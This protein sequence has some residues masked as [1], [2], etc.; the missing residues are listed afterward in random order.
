MQASFFQKILKKE[1]ILSKRF[2]IVR[3]EN[4][5]QVDAGASL[6]TNRRKLNRTVVVFNL[7][8]TVT[9][10]SP[11]SEHRKMKS[12]GHDPFRVAASFQLAEYGT[13]PHMSYSRNHS[14][15]LRTV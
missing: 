14:H 15:R 10:P 2:Q 7:P 11:W 6:P 3:A 12:C 1:L 8:N 13:A 9:V 5:P 4:L